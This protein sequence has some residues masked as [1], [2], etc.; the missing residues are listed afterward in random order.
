MI[1]KGIFIG[2]MVVIGWIVIIFLACYIHDLYDV[3]EANM[4]K[5]DKSRVK[6]EL[7]FNNESPMWYESSDNPDTAWLYNDEYVCNMMEFF[8]HIIKT[9]QYLYVRTIAERLGI[10]PLQFKADLGWEKGIYD[11]FEYQTVANKEKQ[12]IRITFMAAHLV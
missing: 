10:D 8:T 6:V 3:K 7:I 12:E 5:S 4:P 2:I 11:K 1:T 9:S